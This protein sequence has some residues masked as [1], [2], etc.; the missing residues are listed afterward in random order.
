MSVTFTRKMCENCHALFTAYG[1][2]LSE[3]K[4]CPACIADSDSRVKSV[5]LRRQCIQRGVAIIHSLP[6]EWTDREGKRPHDELYWNIDYK[7]SD[8]DDCWYDDKPI[9]RI[10]I[11]ASQPFQVGDIV[12]F[13]I[14]RALH[15]PKMG[16][17]EYELREYLSLY[18]V[19]DQSGPEWIISW[20]V[21]SSCVPKIGWEKEEG[22]WKKSVANSVFS[23]HLAVSPMEY[24]FG[25]NAA[26]EDLIGAATM[27]AI[28]GG[29]L[30]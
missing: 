23:A 28:R 9:G 27:V 30:A 11:N 22:V 13:R 17:G 19:S 3:Q 2:R 7:G 21:Q 15:R 25:Q 29:G 12:R 1:N 16:G 10:V 6:C 24:E 8:L 26:D 4:R 5:P 14:M 20:E 18:P